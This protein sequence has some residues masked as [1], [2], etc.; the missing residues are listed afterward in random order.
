[1]SD[2]KDGTSSRGIKLFLIQ[3]LI[4]G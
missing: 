2:I 1:V 3:K 4:L